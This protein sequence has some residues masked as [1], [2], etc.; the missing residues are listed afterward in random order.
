VLVLGAGASAHLHYP[1]GRELINRIAALSQDALAYP[2]AQGWEPR[3]FIEELSY[4][5]PN[6]IDAFL[7]K[8]PEW[9]E[10][11]RYLITLVLKGHERMTAMFPPATAGW[12]RVLYNAL[13]EDNEDLLSNN[14]LTIVTFN[15]DRSLEAY[16]HRRVKSEYRLSDEQATK[17]LRSIQ[18]IHP[19]GTLGDYP[20]EPYEVSTDSQA[21]HRISRRI[22]IISDLKAA[23]DGFCTEDFR[24]ANQALSAAK[25]IYFV[26]FGFHLEN[27]ER[28]RFFSRA[29]LKEVSILA[30]SPGLYAKSRDD[31]VK[32]LDQFGF[33]P[34]MFQNSASAEF[35][36]A[37]ADLS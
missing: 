8:H 7:T 2:I 15:Y 17:A 25:R 18:I 20:E 1:L 30:S 6:S 26:G 9:S 14:R 35:F 37:I 11:G 13:T 12:Y 21:I 32:R 5:D 36:H 27:V 19:H 22:K 31:L 34:A 16:L 29:A 23:A 28:F 3:Q 33:P 10:L 24:L 4:S